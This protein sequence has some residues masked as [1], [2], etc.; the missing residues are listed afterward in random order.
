MNKTIKKFLLTE[1]IFELRLKQRGF[2]HSACGTFTKHR[3]R[4]QKVKDTGSLK[5]IYIYIYIYIYIEMN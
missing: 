3:E 4:I 2:I 5:H 1:D